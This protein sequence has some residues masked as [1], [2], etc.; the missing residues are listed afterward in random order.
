LYVSQ[1]FAEGKLPS[2]PPEVI[3][4]ARDPG[5]RDPTLAEFSALT[6]LLVGPVDAPYGVAGYRDVYCYSRSADVRQVEHI[7]GSRRAVVELVGFLIPDAAVS[8]RR[9]IGVMSDSNDKMA[10]M[11]LR[12][13]CRS[14]RVQWESE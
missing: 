4:A 8:G 6:W 11:L 3:A 13:G 10:A 12:M 9:C 1:L 5:H 14:D 7:A 2:A